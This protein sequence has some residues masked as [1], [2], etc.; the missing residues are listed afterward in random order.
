MASHFTIHQWSIPSHK[1]H[2]IH[3]TFHPYQLSHPVCFLVFHFISHA[4][5]IVYM[6]CIISHQHIIPSSYF[7]FSVFKHVFYIHFIGWWWLQ[8]CNWKLPNWSFTLCLSQLLF[9]LF[10][11][12]MCTMHIAHHQIELSELVIMMFFIFNWMHISCTIDENAH[13]MIKNWDSKIQIYGSKIYH[14][15]ACRAWNSKYNDVFY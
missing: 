13:K 14:L 9:S 11:I 6:Y 5:I 3:L 1:H 12:Y 10:W 2:L 7:I 8:Y 15:V 4:Y